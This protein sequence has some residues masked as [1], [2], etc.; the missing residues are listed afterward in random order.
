[1]DLGEGDYLHTRIGTRQ[2]ELAVGQVY[3]AG[4]LR[5]YES[6]DDRVRALA[7]KR[8]GVLNAF[9]GSGGGRKLLDFGCGTGRVVDAA[10]AAGWRAS[11]CDVTG[12]RAFLT[13]A[14]AVAS[15]GWHAVTFFD[16]LEHLPDP[17]GCV[18]A[19]GAEWVMVSVPWCHR[20]EDWNWFGPW[21]HRKPG[22]HLWHWNA[23]TLGELFHGL[24]Y[25]AVMANSFED[26]CRP[27]PT[28][29]EPNILT[30]L[31]RR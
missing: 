16:S 11:G 13:P 29:A 21:K 4:Y 3:D 15:G 20:P 17:A 19:L 10:E 8:V 14:Q 27:N 24:G 31:F 28:Q 23:G 12:D 2:R 7:A 6:I 5:W 30:A 25:R 26:E 1:M 9:A 18:S 22:E